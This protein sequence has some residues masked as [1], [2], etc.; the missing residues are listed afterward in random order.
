M[1]LVTKLFLKYAKSAH[2]LRT[3]RGG[4]SRKIDQIDQIDQNP[5]REVL[6]SIN[7]Q[8][9]SI[10]E[11][12]I[13]HNISF[14]MCGLVAVV[15]LVNLGRYTPPPERK[16]GKFVVNSVVNSMILAKKE[17]TTN[18]ESTTYRGW[19]FPKSSKSPKSFIFNTTLQAKH[20]SAIGQ[21]FS[22]ETKSAKGRCL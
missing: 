21:F 20:L 10:L 19:F 12:E 4:I 17:L 7:N 11:I 18:E 14:R 1:N 6:W 16:T 2:F 22:L 9:W 13:D 5:Q 3:A 8:V 15:N